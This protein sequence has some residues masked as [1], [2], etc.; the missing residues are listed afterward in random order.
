M[1]KRNWINRSALISSVLA[2]SILTIG[3]ASAVHACSGPGGNFRDEHRGDK[4]MRVMKKLDLTR[5]Q[6]Q[7]IRNIK[8][9]TRD[10]MET[11]RDEMIDIRKALR[12]QSRAETYDASKV[13]ELANTKS[14]IMADMTVQRIETMN[15]IRKELT[16][17][18]LTQMDK[19]KERR[20]ERG[21]F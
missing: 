17:D 3:A 13:R 14:Q 20:Y 1:K 11:K 2:G 9:E 15:R 6:R 19:L 7:A 12:E 10:Q 16:Q 21:N 18:Q 4:M 8:N 5:E